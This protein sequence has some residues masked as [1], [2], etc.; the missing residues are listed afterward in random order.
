MPEGAS[1]EPVGFESARIPARSQRQALDW[2]LV[3]L[4]QEIECAIDY[5]ELGWALV[6]PYHDYE[7][8]LATLRQ[9]Q[10]ENRHWPWRQMIHQDIL[11]DWASLAWVGLLILF[12]VLDG[13]GVDLK[14]AGM[15]DSVA[16]SHGQW[17]RLCTAIFLHADLG[18][19]ASN[20][21]F[22]LVFLGL[23]MGVY[24]TGTGLLAA[25]LT[26]VGGNAL[27]WI[28]DPAHRSLGASGMVMGCLGLLAAQS[29][30]LWREN[31]KAF[32]L[33]VSSVA[34]GL[35]LFL[36]LGSDPKTDVLAHFGGFASGVLLGSLLSALKKQSLNQTSNLIAGAT[37]TVLV[38][39]SWCLA[40][41]H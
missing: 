24:G 26:G 29:I 2:S 9:Y 38:V 35:M 5:S 32:R 34:A 13:K 30:W 6:V 20:A 33:T 10:I 3:L 1:M 19:L 41:T 27:T 28:I 37:F 16:V 7:R 14:E 4:S 21:G 23:V 36:L 25:F 31:P 18:H 17:W 22:G 15:M 12:F 40:L 11:F 39:V 8:A